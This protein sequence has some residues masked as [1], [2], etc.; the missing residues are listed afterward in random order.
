MLRALPRAGIGFYATGIRLVSANP[1]QP[2]LALESPRR[3]ARNICARI[4]FVTSLVGVAGVFLVGPFGPSVSGIGMRIAFLCV[5]GLLLS[6]AGLFRPPRRLA[7]W[8]VA[9]GVF[10]TLFLPTFCLSLFV[11]RR[12]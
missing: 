3:P 10:G 9:L 5:P 11:F 1:Y 12:S 4:G 6:V 2:P 7:G 8:G